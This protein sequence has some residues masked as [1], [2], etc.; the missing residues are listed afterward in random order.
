MP[1]ELSSRVEA[2]SRAGSP[3]PG[4]ADGGARMSDNL[5][6]VQVE[7]DET[8]AR[9]ELGLLQSQGIEACIL[10]DD[11]GDQ[12]PSLERTQGVKILVPEHQAERARKLLQ[13]REAS[14]PDPAEQGD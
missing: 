9:I 6:V 3:V 2:Q 4:L 14:G 13:E 5:V 10:E 11:L 12:F 7:S 8:K 1:D